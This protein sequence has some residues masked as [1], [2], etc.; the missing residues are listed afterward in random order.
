MSN[1]TNSWPRVP[2][3]PEEWQHFLLSLLYVSILPLIPLVLEFW[4]KGSLTAS[5]LTLTTAIYSVTVGASS[6]NR[7]LFG[8]GILLAFVFSSVFGV[9]MNASAPPKGTEQACFVVLALLTVFNVFDRWNRH[10][11]DREKF[12]DFK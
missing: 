3:L 8:V 9:V 2:D 10:M 7:L 4:L 1:G 5:S 12:W 11:V 6:K